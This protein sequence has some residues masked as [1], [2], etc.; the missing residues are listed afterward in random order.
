MTEFVKSS[1]NKVSRNYEDATGEDQIKSVIS[2]SVN[3]NMMNSGGSVKYW[4]SSK[5]RL[6]QK[7]S[8]HPDQ[9]DQSPA[10]NTLSGTAGT[11]TSTSAANNSDHQLRAQKSEHGKLV[12]HSRTSPNQDN[13]Q[14][15][16]NFNTNTTVRVC[17]DCNTTTTPLWR[18]G[19]RGPKVIN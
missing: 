16:F 5:M 14:F 11:T 19:P 2:K 3:D 13:T 10:T 7:M 17:S 4:M 18:S 8:N 6:I 1:S 12:P 9:S 15:T